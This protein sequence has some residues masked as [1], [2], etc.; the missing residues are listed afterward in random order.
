MKN[1][2]KITTLILTM[3]LFVNC[4]EDEA[5]VGEIIAPTNLVIT[6]EVLGVDAA[7]PNG[8]GSGFVKLTATQTML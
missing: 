2:I 7:N 8:D 1:I 4:Q 3:A 5:E 6:A